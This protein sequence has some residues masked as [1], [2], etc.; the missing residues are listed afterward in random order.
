V[1]WVLTQQC[2]NSCRYCTYANGKEG[3]STVDIIWILEELYQAGVRL[4]SLTGGEILLRKDIG[5]IIRVA[6][7]K[8]FFV[9]IC[10]N[11]FLLAEL[12]LEINLVDVIQLSIDGKEETHDYLRGQGSFS[13]VIRGLEISLANKKDVFLNTVV[14]SYNTGK[15]NEVLEICEQYGVQA[16]FQPARSK[17]YGFS[18]ENLWS[19][20]VEEFRSDV[21]W[22][23]GMK[24][25][26]V[27]RRFIMNSLAGLQH[28]LSWPVPT[29]IPCVAGLT[30]FRI[31]VNGYLH[32]CNDYID[33][34][35][36]I[37][38]VPQGFKH[39]LS[40]VCYLPC[41]EC[42][43]AGQIEGNL[44]MALNPQVIMNY[45]KGNYTVS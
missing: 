29:R 15:L 12:I 25:N 41:Q 2:N 35:G 33:T 8:G 4:L 44:L 32:S 17:A 10:T 16:F 9:K 11:G 42:W 39:A 26:P 1:S 20:Q 45:L 36:G 38:I 3:L 7:A 24:K 30:H 13:K 40:K 18:G 43:G 31:D 34:A 6:K 27:K 14:S 37:S 28:L 19:P 22:L 23:M 21:R 5:H